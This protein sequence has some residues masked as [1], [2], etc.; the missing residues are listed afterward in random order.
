MKSLF[1]L[2][3]LCSIASFSLVACGS[4]Q[5][6][7]Q[8]GN[9]VHLDTIQFAQSSITLHKGESLTLINDSNNSHIIANGLWENGTAQTVQGPGAPQARR[10]S[11]LHQYCLYWA[12]YDGRHIP[13]CTV[14]STRT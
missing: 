9:E 8:T 6:S 14:Q 13:S 5:A 7:A 3:L 12:F 1:V 11:L 2:L 10:C 4:I